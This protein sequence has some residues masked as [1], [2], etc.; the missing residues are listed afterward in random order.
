M[1]VAVAAI[2]FVA[3]LLVGVALA[4]YSVDPHQPRRRRPF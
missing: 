3:G 2:A 4:R 1:L